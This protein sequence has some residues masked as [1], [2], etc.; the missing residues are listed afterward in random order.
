MPPDGAKLLVPSD[1]GANSAP[2]DGAV[3]L[4][5]APDVTHEPGRPAEGPLLSSYF[6]TLHQPPGTRINKTIA[7]ELKGTH[8]WK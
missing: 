5:M 2:G 1:S 7:R 3:R 8:P 6:E 4:L